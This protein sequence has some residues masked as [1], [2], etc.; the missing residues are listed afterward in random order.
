MSA[1][2]F[3]ALVRP[4]RRCRSGPERG[5]S[6][7]IVE[8]SGRHPVNHQL[9]YVGGAADGLD[10][11]VCGQA[12][13]PLQNPQLVLPAVLGEEEP[14]V[15]GRSFLPTDRTN[16]HCCFVHMAPFIAH[17]DSPATRIRSIAGRTLPRCMGILFLIPAGSGTVTI[18]RP[19]SNVRV[20]NEEH[21]SHIQ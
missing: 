20:S 17:R 2:P 10:A 6:K 19:F 5:S 4:Y 14:D 16:I 1:T 3:A 13:S 11:V 12:V 21:S 9:P 8:T 7:G 15:V 18:P